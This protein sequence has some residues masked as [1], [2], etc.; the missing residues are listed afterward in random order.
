MISYQSAVAYSCFRAN[1]ALKVI[2]AE[3]AVMLVLD[4]DYVHSGESDIEEDP[5]FPLPRHESDDELEDVSE[6]AGFSQ[7]PRRSKSSLKKSEK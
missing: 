1:F 3:E 2:S 4:G 6:R 5:S 7:P